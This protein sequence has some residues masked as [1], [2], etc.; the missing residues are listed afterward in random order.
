MHTFGQPPDKIKAPLIR[1]SFIFFVILIFFYALGD[2]IM[3]FMAP[4]LIEDIVKNPLLMGIIFSF[5]SFVG[6]IMDYLLSNYFKE[7]SAFTYLILGI[8]IAIIFPLIFL[9]KTNVITALIAMGIWGLYYELILFA[10]SNYV[11]HCLNHDQHDLGWAFFNAFSSLAYLIGPTFALSIMAFGNRI[12][13]LIVLV[14][15]G[16]ALFGVIIYKLSF[17]R[18]VKNPNRENNHTPVFL[19][20]LRLWRTLNSKLYPVLIYFI[21][22][23][24]C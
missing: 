13:L 19:K 21:F 1:T 10:K 3:S 20:G 15:Q 11:H 5:S 9:L 16:L 6:L 18:E 14:M 4:N 24:Y 8:S 7:K 2:S 17:L 23:Q 12:P 22:A